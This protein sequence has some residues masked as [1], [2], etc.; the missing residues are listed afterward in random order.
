M[1]EFLKVEENELAFPKSMI[2]Q[3]VL[4]PGFQK[5]GCF[6]ELDKAIDDLKAFNPFL[7]HEFEGIGRRFK[8]FLNDYV[9]PFLNTENISIKNIEVGPQSGLESMIDEI[10]EALWI[11]GKELKIRNSKIKKMTERSGYTDYGKMKEEIN[12]ACFSFLKKVLP[13]ESQNYT[14]EQYEAELKEGKWQE[15]KDFQKE[16]FANGN[17]KEA[18]ELVAAN[19]G[20]DMKTLMSVLLDKK[21]EGRDGQQNK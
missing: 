9:L 11:L 16:I 2:S 6:E 14:Y 12:K 4:K 15:I 20:M 3:F 17:S 18:I 10:D 19:E 13:P 7:Y 1:S 5:L 8:K 21:N